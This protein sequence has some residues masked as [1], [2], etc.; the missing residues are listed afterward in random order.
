VEP[1][2][3]DA[4]PSDLRPISLCN[5]LYKIVAKVLANLLL[6]DII[7][8]NQSDFVPGRLISDNILIAYEV[9]HYLRNRRGRGESYAAIK[10]DMCKAYDRGRVGFLA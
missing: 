7:S 2:C 8:P 1:D 4:Y 6:P 5:V 3:G 10:L 9:A